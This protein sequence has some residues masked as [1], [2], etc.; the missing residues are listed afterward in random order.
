MQNTIFHIDMDAFFAAIEQRD[1]PE[2]RGKPLIVGAK[3]GNRGVVSTCSYEA[4]EFGVH[5]AMP[6][7]QAFAR[8]PKGIFVPPR[9]TVYRE[10]S[11]K[12]MEIFTQFSPLVEPLSVDEAFLDMSGTEKLMGD[13]LTIAKEILSTIKKELNL[14]ASIGVAP[15]KFLAKLAS[16]VKKPNGITITPFEKE[17]IINWL[18]P[19]KVERIWGVGG[20]SA[21][22]MHRLGVITIGDLQ[23]I[24]ESRLISIFG[25]S[26]A[27]FSNLRFGI[28]NRSV[29]TQMA[30]KSISREFT[31]GEDEFDDDVWRKTLLVLVADICSTARK[32]GVKAKTITLVHRGVDFKRHTLSKTLSTPTNTTGEVNSIVLE[33]LSKARSAINGLRLIGASLSSFGS[34]AQLS[35]FDEIEI[36]SSKSK[37]QNED[38]ALDAVVNKFGKLS[39]FRGS[40]K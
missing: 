16:D 36:D 29:K 10:V 26:G 3:P 24:E 11:R 20:E 13:R 37:W 15:N 12:L 7:S 14:T 18:A 35:L 22:K 33:L 31:F 8:C 30:A 9:M 6:I 39:I 25:K 21:K 27:N 4:R 2:Y 17:E 23:K 34:E 38:R 19:L 40:E 5:S 32:K 28:D 1:F